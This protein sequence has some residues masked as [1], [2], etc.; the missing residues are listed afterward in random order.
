M[1]G[2]GREPGG[3]RRTLKTVKLEKTREREVV[4]RMRGKKQNP[5]GIRKEVRS[6][7]NS[8]ADPD[9]GVNE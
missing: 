4:G 3:N 2:R 6:R 5:R 7:E 9:S 8:G 1:N